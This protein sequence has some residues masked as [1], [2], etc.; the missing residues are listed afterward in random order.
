MGPVSGAV[1]FVIIWWLVLFMVLP[2]GVQTQREAG[3]EVVPGT[4][5]SAPAR[6][7]IGLKFAITT[8]A[9]SVLWA[10]VYAIIKYE[11]IT[12]G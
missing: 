5:E 8:A 3:D 4:A 10:I 11:I 7:R 12:I 6:P 9:T 1:T 2:V